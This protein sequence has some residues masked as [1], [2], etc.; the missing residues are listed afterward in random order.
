MHVQ[1]KHGYTPRNACALDS[2]FKG[3]YSVQPFSPG[4]NFSFHTDNG[5][6]SHACL[7]ETDYC[8]HH[9]SP[10]DM[11]KHT[12]LCLCLSVHVGTSVWKDVG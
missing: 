12:P 5:N 9:R 10:E 8:F 11:W 4:A 3:V 1:V 7:M 6:H 2:L